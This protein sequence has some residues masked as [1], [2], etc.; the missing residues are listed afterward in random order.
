MFVRQLF[1]QDTFTYT[2]LVAD[3]ATKTAALVDPV[4]AQVERDL[5]LLDEL[6]LK[7]TH[8]LETHVHADHVTAAGVLRER[9]GARV[10][11]ARCGAECADLKVGDGDEIHVGSVVIRV[12]E[13]PGHTDDSLSFLIDNQVL[14]G[15]ALFVRGT[16]R[17]DFQNGSADA[18]WTS[19]TE[20]LWTLPDQTTVWPGHDYRGH[21]S[22]TIGEE[23]RC[24]PRLAGKSKADFLAIMAA[25][26]LPRPKYL[27]VAVPANKECGLGV[28][29]SAD[30]TSGFRELS[31]NDA[32][33]FV[34]NDSAM[35]IDVR[36]P[37]ELAGELGQ[38]P[39]AVNVPRGEISQAALDLSFDAP[40]L[41]VCR[42]GRRSR[43]VCEALAKR[44]FRNVVNLAGGM[45]EYRETTQG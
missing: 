33:Q 15:D 43:A 31:T 22:S 35:V 38:F 16:G 3:D 39:S 28:A 1:D 17:T 9:T 7:L 44:G 42:S 36:E 30:G 29:P 5:K 14:T 2:Y 12:L 6:G 23:K 13:T 40:L 41:V 19:I 32:L 27:D 45:L 24:N 8:V 4:L 18:L 20:K 11:A 21:A 37:H 34:A 25:L 10:A 26:N